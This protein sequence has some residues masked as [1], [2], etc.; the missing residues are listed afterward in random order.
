MVGGHTLDALLAPAVRAEPAVALYWQARGFTAPLFL[1]VAGWA[2]TE[3]IGRGHA[4]GAALVRARLPRVGLLVAVGLGLRWPGWGVDGLRRLDPEVW[5]HLLAFDALQTIAVGLLVSAVLLA[6]PLS[7]RERI[8]AFL[9]LVVAALALATLPPAPPARAIAAIVLQQAAGGTSPFPLFPWV[10]YVFAGAIL[11]L[12]TEGGAPRTALAVGAT[13]ILLVTPFAIL[14]PGE[15]A[16]A[17]P[18]LVGLRIGAVLVALALLFAVPPAAARLLAPVG[19]A[20]LAVYAIHVAV[21][22]GWSTVHGLSSRIGPTLG[23][24]SA[25]GLAAAV[26]AGSYAAARSGA[27][28]RAALGLYAARAWRATKSTARAS[29][30]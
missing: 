26:L 5:R 3:A 27:L 10:A 24:P 9:A 21:V 18:V 13:G 17:H 1:L 19:R 23:F 2:V 30:Q 25:L 11:G 16:P 20:S 4:R 7:R 29:A 28:L 6:L 22:Y 15:F 14:S 12:A 8:L